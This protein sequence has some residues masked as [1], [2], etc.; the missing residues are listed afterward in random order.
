MDS[1]VVRAALKSGRSRSKQIMTM[2]R[3]LFWIAVE[4]NFIFNSTYINTNVNIISALSRL[5]SEVSTS[6]IRAVDTYRLMCCT[7]LFASPILC[8]YRYGGT[9]EGTKRV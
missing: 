1:A 7:H 4:N 9:E 2:V 5:D 8:R 3:E 6:R